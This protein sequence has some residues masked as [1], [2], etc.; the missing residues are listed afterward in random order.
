MV[1]VDG[2]PPVFVTEVLGKNL[3]IS[4]QDHD[5]D[6]L[7]LQNFLDLSKTDVVPCIQTWP[8]LG[9]KRNNSEYLLLFQGKCDETRVRNKG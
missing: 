3:H 6:R 1:D 8:L 7:P 4:R 5:V 9:D 2:V